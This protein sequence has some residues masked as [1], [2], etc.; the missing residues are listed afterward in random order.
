MKD[1]RIRRRVSITK[2]DYMKVYE[3]GET[4]TDTLEL[5]GTPSMRTVHIKLTEVT[6]ELQKRKSEKGLLTCVLTSVHKT[7]NV[8]SMSV[9]DFLKHAEVAT[10]ET[11]AGEEK[12][13]EQENE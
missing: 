5:L 4:K 7:E 6:K 13:E 9:D 3:N 10:P 12:E 11:E 1:R 2:V 8:Y